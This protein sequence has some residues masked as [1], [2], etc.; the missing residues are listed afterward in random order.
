[1][2]SLKNHFLIAMPMLNDPNFSE[3][4]TYMCR[5]SDDE[6]AIGIVVN[7]PGTTTIGEICSQLDIGV[8]DKT[9]AEVPVLTGGP[10]EPAR[11]F[12]LHDGASS[13]ES[14]IPV[15][16][17]IHLTASRDILEAIASGHGPSRLVVALGY[18]GWEAGQL[19]A[20]IAAN[21]WLVV[22]ARPEI[23]FDTP[24]EQRW[25]AA[26]HL[27]GIDIHEISSYSGRA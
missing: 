19:E 24:Y 23:I 9:Y 22:E 12:V 14:T 8:T 3:A 10:V 15:S 6:G 1:M 25:A 16:E 18:A 7:R 17:E 11:G 2:D 4:V 20:E 5:H 26:A 21:A 27:I 13:Y